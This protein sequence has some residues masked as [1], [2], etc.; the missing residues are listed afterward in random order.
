MAQPKENSGGN[1]SA[2]NRAPA[3]KVLAGA[4]ANS[5]V[6]QSLISAL[7]KYS[8]NAILATST[9]QT[10]NFGILKAGDF[11]IHMASG[12]GLPPGSPDLASAATYGLLAKSAIST[13]N[14]S[15]VNGD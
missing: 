8:L 9:S 10:L 14:P 5:R 7:G 11:V 3:A 4:L 12:S 2:P 13:V 6:A 15:F 1:V